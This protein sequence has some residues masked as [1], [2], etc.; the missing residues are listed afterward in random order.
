MPAIASALPAAPA[1]KATKKK[2]KVQRPVPL[3]RVNGHTL[4]TTEAKWVRF[5]ATN[6]VP[7]LKGTLAQ[8]LDQA[9]AVAWWSLKEG[10][11]G[12]DNAVAYSNANFS[13][14][15]RRIGPLSVGVP[16][17][18]WQVGPSGVQVTGRSLAGIEQLAK[19]IYPGKSIT[20]IL[21]LTARMAKHWRGTATY[22]GI[23]NAKGSLRASWLLRNPAIGTALQAPAVRAECVNSSR[24]W[25]YGTAWDTTSRYAPNKTAALNSIRT[26][27][28]YF[29]KVARQS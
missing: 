14:G 27:R 18:A 22:R 15:D 9:A 17:R 25:C 16:G 10:V 20:Q 26:L 7:R 28:A 19:R 5:F 24:G 11:L 2:K 6:V 12:I 1:P 23:V 8:R 4:R 3:P 29:L 21:D 13:G